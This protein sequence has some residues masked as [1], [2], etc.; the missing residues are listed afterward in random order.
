M[1]IEFKKGERQYHNI[2]YK[3]LRKTWYDMMQRCYNENHHSYKWYGAEGVTVCE[4]W[5]TLDGFLETVDTVEGWDEDKYK[6]ET[7]HLDKDLK[8]PGNKVY[9]PETC[10]FVSPDENRA[11]THEVH[12]KDCEAISPSGKKY[13]FRNKEAFCRE[14]GLNP[15]NVYFCLIGKQSNHKGWVFRYSDGST[16]EIKKGRSR[17]KLKIAIDPEGNEHIFRSTTQFAKEHNLSVSCITA[18][19][20]GERKHHKQWRFYEKEDVWD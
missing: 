7:M 8:V 19:L 3:K 14:H 12:M 4:E 18:V 9:S 20:R 5:Q 13:V 1:A 15:S 6:R 16:P 17:M 11:P 10:M 2:L